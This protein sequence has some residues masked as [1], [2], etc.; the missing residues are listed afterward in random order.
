MDADSLSR[1]FV[2]L[3][4][5][6]DI[7]KCARG[8]QGKVLDLWP[9]Y[10]GPKPDKELSVRHD[11]AGV[12]LFDQ[13]AKLEE[14][15]ERLLPNLTRSQRLIIIQAVCGHHGE[16]IEWRMGGDYPDIG[17]RNRDIGPKAGEAAAKIAE[18]IV[19]MLAPHPCHLEETSVPLASFWLS[20][21]AVLSDWLGS[22]RT[23]FEFRPPPQ[24]GDLTAN[25][26]L[27]W[28]THALPGA[29]KALKEAGLSSGDFIVVG[30]SPIFST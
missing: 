23:W 11:A 13:N 12:W 4:A 24:A 7:G 18:A 9:D 26:A 15:A 3:I 22:N 1:C 19:A 27:Y 14:I 17:N 5:L 10:L 8:F 2:T 6:H 28:K 30:P 20:G 25:M 21:L 16:P 29:K